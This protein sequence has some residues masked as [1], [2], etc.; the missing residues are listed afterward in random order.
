MLP[1]GG[2]ILGFR[3]LVVDTL[4][5]VFDRSHRRAFDRAA[6]TNV[7]ADPE[8]EQETPRARSGG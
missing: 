8:E 6:G 5:A 7:V 3:V 2:P 4:M 1:P